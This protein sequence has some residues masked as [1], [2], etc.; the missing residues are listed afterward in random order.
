[1][2]NLRSRLRRH[3]TY[4]NL[5][6]SIAV[7]LALGGVGYAATAINGNDIAKRTVGANK[8][9]NGTLTAKQVKQN[10]LTG[11]V[12]DESS[13]ATVPSAQTAV[14]AT[15]ATSAA[16]ATT[17]TTAASATTAANATHAT[18]AD[19]ATEATTAATAATAATAGDADTLDGV[20]SKELQVRCPPETDPYGGMCWDE[21]VRPADDW[22]GAS[23]ECGDEGGRLPS[24][25]ELIGYTFQPGEQVTSQ[26]WTGDVIDLPG[27]KELVLTSDESTTSSSSST[28]T[29][30]GYRCL[31]YPTN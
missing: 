25:S 30:L 4:A 27:G 7:F 24:L 19:R 29:H 14:S 12:I 23:I 9:K 31:F 26:N 13:L 22:I 16:S 8:L 15:N 28:P 2:T 21:D 5:M 1:M 17:A 18:S 10:A 20:T 11:S 6:A 3:L